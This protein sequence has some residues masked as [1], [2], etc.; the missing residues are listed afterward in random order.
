MI[1][2]VLELLGYER[3]GSRVRLSALL[4]DWPRAGLTVPFGASR[5]HLICEKSAACVTL[6]GATIDEDYIEM[7]D[8]GK[9]H[10]A[11]F[12][13]RSEGVKMRNEE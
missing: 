4:G 12:P 11:V 1:V 3:R 6:D 5:Y 7:V 13:G 2:C 9:E 8:D 10:T